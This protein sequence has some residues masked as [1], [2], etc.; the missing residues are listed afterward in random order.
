MIRQVSSAKRLLQRLGHEELVDTPE[1]HSRVSSLGGSGRRGYFEKALGWRRLD[2][3]RAIYDKELRGALEALSAVKTDASALVWRGRILRI[4]GDTAE[5]RRVLE[6]SR[7]LARTP[8]AAA[9]LGELALE[10]SPVEAETLLSE[11]A[12]LAPRW[13]LPHLIRGL[14]R[15]NA[16]KHAD[17]LAEFD[18]A[19]R[20][21]PK[22]GRHLMRL[23]RS[24]AHLQALRYDQAFAEAK[25]AIR[26]DPHSPAGYHMAGVVKFFAGE[27]SAAAEYS[28][29][30]RN[31]D[32]NLEGPFFASWGVVSDW[33]QPAVYLETLDRAIEKAPE[34]AVL[35]AA[36]AE[37]KRDPKLC[38][39]DEALSDYQKAAELAPDCAWIRAALARAED[40]AHGGRNGLK[41]FALALRLCRSSGWAYAWRG[42]VWARLGET[43]RALDDFARAVKLMPW[44][45][46]TYA[47]RGALLNRLGRAAEALADLDTAILLDPHYPFSFNERFQAKRAL[48]DD[49]GAAADLN[50]AFAFNP[51]YT[52]M[53]GKVSET[54]PERRSEL[55][56]GLDDAIVRSPNEAWLHAWRGYSLLQWG[57]SDAALADFDAAA[58][59]GLKGAELE[60]WRGSALF[61]LGRLDEAVASLEKSVAS[62]PKGWHALTVL[63]EVRS[64]QGKKPEALAAMARAAELAPTT[65]PVLVSQAR[66]EH[67]LGRDEQALALLNR[68]GELD[69]GFADVYLLVAEIRLGRGE[70][71]AA[72]AAAEKALALPQP[73]GK[74]YLVRGLVRQSLGDYDG[75]LSDFAAAIRIDPG[76]FPEKERRQIQDLVGQGKKES[77]AE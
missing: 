67:E 7:A 53:G 58:A 29:Q 70:T 18:A 16:L 35:Y 69:R 26:L 60:G 20:A 54:D 13:A 50:R 28:D 12:S 77:H 37:L 4:L 23:A 75:Q 49:A 31:R 64:A 19:L 73:S 42:A 72:K 1:S 11:S 43:R 3:F 30:A 33:D 65:V 41:S 5:A 46:F 34:Q 47:W 40:L 8:E 66:L 59:R 10:N 45:S 9:W 38:L 44:Y 52:W 36:R 51:K 55:L 62:N 21:E 39:Y 27:L 24:E 56:R 48:K 61:A 17:A 68:A 22:K 2:N 63:A 76:L 25:L 32:Y 57:Q 6:R 14:A 15:L 74:A 71:E